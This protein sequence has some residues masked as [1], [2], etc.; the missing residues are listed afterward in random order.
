M[1]NIGRKI[2]KGLSLLI[3]DPKQL[4]RYISLYI[5]P[6]W[7]L[8]HLGGHIGKIVFDFDFALDSNVKKMYAGFY[9]EKTVRF[10]KQILKPGD[11]FIDVGSNIGYLSAV[12]AS[13]VGSQG[14]VYCFEPVPIFFMRL[15]QMASRN[16]RHR[17]VV[18]QCALGDK[19]GFAKIS[20]TNIKNIGWNTMVPGFMSKETTRE[21]VKVPMRRLDAYIK[22][23]GI[24]NISLIKIDVEGFEFPVLRGLSSFFENKNNRPVIVCEIIPFA[25]HLLGYSLSQLSEYMEGYGYKAYDMGNTNNEIDIL[26]L[27]NNNHTD[28]AFICL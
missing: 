19:E 25:Y 11:T 27:R 16:P 3:N 8:N 7:L 24:K 28:V 14:Q 18:N 20:I 10:F 5:M 13:L 17:I 15:K 2:K 6:S 23:G 26:A 1:K 9:E 12:G 21:S 4:V 22:K